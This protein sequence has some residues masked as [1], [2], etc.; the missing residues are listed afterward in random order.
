MVCLEIVA[1]PQKEAWCV[2]ATKAARHVQ[3]GFLTELS[4]G[5]VP[6]LPGVCVF[7]EEKVASTLS[8][9]EGRGDTDL[10]LPT[11]LPSALTALEFSGLPSVKS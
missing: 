5:L 2:S 8:H 4:N 10:P 6:P 7:A 1:P 3:L 9:S 11:P